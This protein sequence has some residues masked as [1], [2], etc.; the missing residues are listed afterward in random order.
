MN[1][2]GVG[3]GVGVGCAGVGISPLILRDK[4]LL[5]CV[6]GVGGRV[7]LYWSVIAMSEDL[8]V[9]LKSR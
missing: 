5:V 9:G 8:G 6:G 4:R 7:Y 1:G 3:V 2:D